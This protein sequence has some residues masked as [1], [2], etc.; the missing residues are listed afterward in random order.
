VAARAETPDEPRSILVTRIRRIGDV[1]L[2]L[3]VVDALHERFPGAAIDYLAEREPARAV[4]GHPAVRRVLEYRPGSWPGLPA[5][6]DLLARLRAARYDWVLDLY[7][8]PRSALLAR[9]TG[10]RVRVGPARRGRGRLYTHAIPPVSEPVSAVEHHLAS[11]RPLGLAPEPRAP[12][13]HLSGAERA[14]GSARLD[15]AIPS[16]A[17]R[18]GLHVGN[19][20]PAKR[21]PEERF[22]ALL[23]TL[24]KIGAAGVIL[25]GPGEEATARRVAAGARDST[26]TGEPPVIAG[27]PL[28][29]YFGVVASLDALVTNDG[30]PLHAGPALG[31]PTVGI[32][33]PTVPEIWFPYSAAHGH[34]LLAKE[35]WCRP[36]HRHECARLDCLEW[37]EVREAL[38]A[39]ERALAPREGA[40]ATA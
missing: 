2:T 5:P 23:R 18:V 11:L 1:I 13:I 38:R 14:R 34:Q 33:G 17:P 9:I 27:L 4:L 15:Q 25:A 10:A 6:P 26:G 32:L 35:I 12:R 36:C 37:I 39:V 28:R 31:V 22:E 3:P 29:D 16:G 24:P 7:G 30:S 40:R 8:N 21:W 19:R 20:W